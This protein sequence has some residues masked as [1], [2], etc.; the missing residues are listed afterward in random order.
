VNDVDPLVALAKSSNRN[1]FDRMGGVLF[2]HGLSRDNAAFRTA[3]L[4][5]L[6]CLKRTVLERSFTFL[7]I[8]EPPSTYCLIVEKGLSK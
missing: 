3:N 6:P 8:I 4:S 5:G 2:V 1:F 7:V